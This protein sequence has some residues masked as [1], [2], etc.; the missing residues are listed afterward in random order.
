MPDELETTL[1]LTQ[2]TQPT[3]SGRIWDD[4]ELAPTTL[5]SARF[6]DLTR[7]AGSDGAR[8]LVA[9][10]TGLVQPHLGRKRKLARRGL[11]TL[12]ANVAAILGG[13]LRT[14]FKGRPVAAQRRPAGGMWHNALIGHDA[15]WGVVDALC[16]AKL[17]N[18]RQ[19]TKGAGIV[20]DDGGP[21]SYNRKFGGQPSKLW[22]SAAL[23]RLAEAHGVTAE[24]VVADWP[25]SRKAETSRPKVASGEL[26]I[27]LS[28]DGDEPAQLS[29]EQMAELDIYRRD[30]AALNDSVAT[31]DIRGCRAPVFRRVFRHDLR[32]EGRFWALGDG[33]YQ[34][35]SEA[36]RLRM[37]IGGEPVAEVDIHA[38]NLTIFLALTGTRE[39]P[40]SDLYDRLTLPD[41]TNIP[42]A[43]VKSWMVQTFGAGKLRSRW[44][45]DTPEAAKVVS[46]ALIRKAALHAYSA[47]KDLKAILPP[48]LAA[49]LPPNKR[50]WAVGQY[51]TNWE[52]RVIQGALAYVRARG[53]VGLPMHDAI[54]VPKGAAGVARSGLEGA[55]LAF[56]KVRPKL[57]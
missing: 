38:C 36:E 22:P 1:T 27:C 14:G 48:D 50:A 37:T 9:E 51:L 55:F 49:S 34:N 44:G 46:P 31:A 57:K 16:A 21:V 28:L 25:V 56:L 29:A 52:S 2:S 17:V 35:M 20:W 39:L 23:M 15:F 26:A 8:D 41:G 10:V 42:R 24:T 54:I 19:G 13:L 11:E 4:T 53:V 43:A 7:T 5:R 3:C 32:L 40:P 47:L 12:G 45:W 33:N 18:Y 30:V 6:I